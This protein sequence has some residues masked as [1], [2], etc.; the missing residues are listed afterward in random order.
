MNE[1]EIRNNGKI[2]MTYIR[3][4]SSCE[5]VK[6]NFAVKLEADS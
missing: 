6:F 3:E 5:P 2:Q 4:Y 1:S